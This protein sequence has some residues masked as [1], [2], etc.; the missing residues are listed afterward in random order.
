MAQPL[1]EEKERWE[2]PIVAEVR[3]ARE[4]LFAAAGYDLV[5][6]CRRLREQ[7]QREDR[8]TVTRHP[9][10]PGRP[11]AKAAGRKPNR[12]IQPPAP[13]TRRG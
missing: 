11:R 2:D 12:R 9:R 1:P 4:E 13:K 6:F 7:Q 5:E 3:R 10:R 8:T